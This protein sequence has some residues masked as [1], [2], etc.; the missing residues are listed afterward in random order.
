MK[1]I[2][3]EP[4]VLANGTQLPLSRAVAANGFIY[5]SGQLGLGEDAKLVGTGVSE[6]TRQALTNISAILAQ[7]GATLN[8]VL[9]VNG[10]LARQGDFSDFNAA[11]ADFFKTSPPAR[12]TVVSQ[13]LIPGALVEL[14][15]VAVCEKR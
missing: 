2:I 12:S 14:E 13:L 3:G 11:Y 4:L 15:A 7:A 9:K 6:Q 8:H 1:D 10:W 5:I